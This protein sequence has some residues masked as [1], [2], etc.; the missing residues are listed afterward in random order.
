MSGL[1]VVRFFL[2]P[3]DLPTE[4]LWFSAY[5]CVRMGH[6]R[7]AVSPQALEREPRGC[8]VAFSS[9]RR[10]RGAA[11]RCGLPVVAE[12]APVSFAPLDSRAEAGPEH[13]G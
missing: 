6:A 5:G 8:A 11:E 1:H 9:S 7:M 2:Q 10:N 13:A 4:N 3:H 12:S